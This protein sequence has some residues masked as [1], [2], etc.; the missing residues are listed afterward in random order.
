[1]HSD[2]NGAHNGINLRELAEDCGIPEGNIEFTDGYTLRVGLPDHR[3]AQLY[4][5]FDVLLAASYGE[6]FGIPV[7]EAQACGTPVI[8]SDFT[9]QPELCGAGWKIPT[10]PFHDFL[11]RSWFGVPSVGAITEALIEARGRSTAEVAAQAGEARRFALQYDQPAVWDRYW[12]P[13]MRELEG[14]LPGSWVDVTIAGPV[15]A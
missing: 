2:E 8:V 15:A 3:M 9:A 4:S 12:L 1:M 13:V 5:A 6:G 7:V 11:Q 10:Q 14:R